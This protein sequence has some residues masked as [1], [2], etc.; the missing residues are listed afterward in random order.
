MTESLLAVRL[1]EGV[2]SDREL[3]AL[4]TERL[5][6]NSLETRARYAQSILKWFFAD[7]P[8]SLASQ[9]WRAYRDES[10]ERDILRALYLRAEPIMGDCVAQALYPLADGMAIPGTFFDGFLAK[11][12]GS[13]EIPGNTR[14]RLKTNLAKLGF[15]VRSRAHGDRLSAVNATRT[16]FLVLLHYL[17]APE[18]PRTIELSRLFADQFWKYLGI[19]SEDAVRVILRSADASRSIGKYIVADQLEQ[20]TTCYSLNELLSQRVVL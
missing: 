2:G 20:I 11:R 18:G 15:L 5:P 7:G 17:F 14:K 4:L 9:V 6:Q 3:E 16:G 8:D 13:Q 1:A 12:L 10:I 19:K